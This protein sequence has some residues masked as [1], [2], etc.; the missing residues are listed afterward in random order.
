M[1]L[2]ENN[3]SFTYKAFRAAPAKDRYDMKIYGDNMSLEYNVYRCYNG[4]KFGEFNQ[5]CIRMYKR[6]P[7]NGQVEINPHYPTEYGHA[8]IYRHFFDCIRRGEKSTISNGERGLVT[9]QILDAIE[10]SILQGGKQVFLK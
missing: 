2:F 9:M 5:D 8:A 7:Y 1:V 3:A 4:H 6:D 10:Q